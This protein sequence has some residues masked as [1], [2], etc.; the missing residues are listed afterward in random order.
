MSTNDRRRK[1]RARVQIDASWEGQRAQ[2]GGLVVDLSETG[3][4]ILTSDRVVPNEVVR[5]TLDPA[6]E[7]PVRLWGEVVYQVADMGFALRFVHKHE[8][9]ELWHARLITRLLE[10]HC[11]L[12]AV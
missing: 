2:C 11:E 4:F 1:Q 6:S 5:L 8:P 12:A 3:C 7:R 9:E 10:E